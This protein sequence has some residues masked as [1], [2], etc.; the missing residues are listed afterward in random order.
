MSLQQIIVKAKCGTGPGVNSM[1]GQMN[2]F[3]FLHEDRDLETLPENE[4]VEIIGRETGLPFRHNAY[5]GDY[6]VKT[7]NVVVSIEYSRY[8]G[9]YDNKKFI[10]VDLN[11]PHMGVSCSC[12]TIEEAVSLINKELERTYT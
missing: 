7:G 11:G 4:M 12:D 6:R 2:I 5:F 8:E 10:G 1:E 9:C 3:D